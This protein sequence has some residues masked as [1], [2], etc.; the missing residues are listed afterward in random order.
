MLRSF[1]TYHPQRQKK[2]TR[3][4]GFFVA[5]FEVKNGL[6]ETSPTVLTIK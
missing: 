5:N 4:G 2:I 6:L 3:S 1:K